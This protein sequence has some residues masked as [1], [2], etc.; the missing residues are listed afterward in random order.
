V[1]D[2]FMS[3][4]EDLTLF[5]SLKDRMAQ[6]ELMIK[7]LKQR[8][9]EE[10]DMNGDKD[11]KGH[12][13]WNIGETLLQR[14]RRTKTSQDFEAAERI[15]NE[16]NLYDECIKYVPAINEDAVY[17]AFQEGRLTEEDLQ[18]IYPVEE[19]WALVIPKEK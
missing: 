18:E 10:V 16:K 11:S 14:Q 6:L 5:L 9:S 13:W 15:F 1:G 19:S 12:V 8:I 4:E 2:V 17:A 3:L 7:P